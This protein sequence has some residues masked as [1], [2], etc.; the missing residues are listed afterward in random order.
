MKDVVDIRFTSNNNEEPV[1]APVKQERGALT[2]SEIIDVASR[3][4]RILAQE[5]HLLNTMNM[6]E[7]AKLQEEKGKLVSAL[8][9]QKK[10]LKLDPAIKNGFLPEEIREFENISLMFDEILKENYRQL[11]RVKEVNRKV[12][13]VIAKAVAES[14]PSA[15]GYGPT[16]I[17]PSQTLQHTPLSI[18]QNA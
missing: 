7:V 6:K 16:G 1:Q 14:T 11:L 4:G 17:V 5:T 13:E 15:A 12:V 2:L 18:S 3:L 10:I 8:E 9:I